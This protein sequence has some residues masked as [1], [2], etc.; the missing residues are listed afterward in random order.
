MERCGLSPSHTRTAL[1]TSYEKEA[2][3]SCLPNKRRLAAQWVQPMSYVVVP[4]LSDLSEMDP[5]TLWQVGLNF[6][7]TSSEHGYHKEVLPKKKL[8]QSNLP[9]S[10]AL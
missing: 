1:L 7:E 9:P 4:L 8:L 5:L 3:T 10:L 2:P 6:L